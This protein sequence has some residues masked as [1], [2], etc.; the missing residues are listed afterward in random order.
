MI[1]N[2]DFVNFFTF[3]S[4]HTHTLTYARIKKNKVY[5]NFMNMKKKLLKQ[6]FFSFNICIQLSL[7]LNV[8][9]R[10]KEGEIEKH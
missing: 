5:N 10:K 2:A 9:E 7:T 3:Y 1:L 6:V 4:A 8:S